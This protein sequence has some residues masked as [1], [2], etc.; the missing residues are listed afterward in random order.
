[1]F[2]FIVL[3]SCSG[4][5]IRVPPYVIVIRHHPSSLS[6]GIACCFLFFWR[7]QILFKVCACKLPPFFTTLTV[8]RSDLSLLVD[9]RVRF[10]T[11]CTFIF[12]DT[13]FFILCCTLRC[14]S[15]FLCFWSYCRL[16]LCGFRNICCNWLFQFMP[17]ITDIM[18]YSR[19]G[20]DAPEATDSSPKSYFAITANI[21][22]L[23]STS[24][25]PRAFFP[26]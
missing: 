20:V 3:T 11:L 9:L 13:D 24:R 5:V 10:A 4:V 12:F 7:S 17:Y 8:W 1:M 26:G 2:K 21:S 18:R 16:I 14:T 22:D 25:S 23:I 19:T 15:V 6:T